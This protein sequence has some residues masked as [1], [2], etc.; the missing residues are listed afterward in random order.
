MPVSCIVASIT[1]HGRGHM[2]I[3]A[4]VLELLH[5]ELPHCRL[6]VWSGLAEETLRA[7]IHCPFDT[8]GDPLDF[9]LRMGPDLTVDV[10]R[11]MNDYAD[12]HD[13]WDEHLTRR[14][15]RLQ[16][17]GASLLL[18]NISFL[19]IAAAARAGIP[20]IAL[21]PLNWADLYHYYAPETEATTAVFGRIVEAYNRCHTFLAPRPCMP[22]P[23]IESLEIIPPVAQTGHDRRALLRECF[24]LDEETRLLLLALGGRETELGP[25]DLPEIDGTRWLVEGRYGLDRYDILP[26]NQ[27]GLMFPDLLA[28]SDVLICKPGYGAFTEAACLGKPVVYIRQPDWPEEVHLI[29]WLEGQVPCTEARRNDPGGLERAVTRLLGR[30]AA[31]C[32]DPAGIQVCVQR[33]TSLLG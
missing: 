25:G 1:A 7:R 31:R 24:D 2:G 15:E 3:T 17:C 5:A 29:D 13:R 10:E 22:M 18:S 4:P 19:N 12:L 26:L 11:T 21:S 6:S 8:V 16:E 28:S 33:I 32:C 20:A 27:A 9:G 30:T 14:V 23:W